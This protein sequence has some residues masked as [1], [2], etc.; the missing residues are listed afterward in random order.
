M[1]FFR[2]FQLRLNSGNKKVFANEQSLPAAFFTV[3]MSC[4]LTV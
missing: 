4:G 3:K 2:A 1:Q